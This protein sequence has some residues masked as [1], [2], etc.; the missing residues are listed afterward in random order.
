MGSAWDYFLTKKDNSD[1]IITINKAI[2][3]GYQ[4]SPTTPMEEP[5]RRTPANIIGNLI[6]IIIISG[7]SCLMLLR[8]LL[9]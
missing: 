2:A 9:D 5:I 1:Q 4:V 6:N 7:I 8:S 3:A